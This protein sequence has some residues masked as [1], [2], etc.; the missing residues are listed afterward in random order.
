MLLKKSD[1][2][3]KKILGHGKTIEQN[4]NMLKEKLNEGKN[5][6]VCYLKPY[7]VQLLQYTHT[8]KCLT[9]VNQHMVVNSIYTDTDRD[10]YI[11]TAIHKNTHI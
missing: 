3:C 2:D 9:A 11:D 6:I 7:K 10:R 1:L 8:L 5:K 4:M